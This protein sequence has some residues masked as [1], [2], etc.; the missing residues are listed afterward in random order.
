MDTYVILPSINPNKKYD[1]MKLD[2]NKP[3]KKLLSFGGN[4]EIYSDYTQHKD[5]LR[6]DNYIKRHQV[7]E[8][9]T[10]LKKAGTWSRYILWNEKTINKSIKDMES[11]FHIKIMLIKNIPPRL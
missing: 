10:N 6:K 4:P 1:V 2:P 11:R 7:N 5:E 3:I 9:W 8:D